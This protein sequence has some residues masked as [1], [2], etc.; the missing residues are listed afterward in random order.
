MP[1][2]LVVALKPAAKQLAL[3]PADESRHQHRTCGLRFVGWMGHEDEVRDV[4]R[5]GVMSGHMV[6]HAARG[7]GGGRREEEW[8]WRACG[9]WR[10]RKKKGIAVQNGVRAA[11]GGRGGGRRGGRSVRGGGRGGRGKGGGGEEGR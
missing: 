3:L 10:K 11:E 1:V 6:M 9:E 4:P 5:L 8:G 2:Q 7:R